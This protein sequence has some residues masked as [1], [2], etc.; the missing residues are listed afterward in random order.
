M[1]RLTGVVVMVAV[2]VMASPAVAA[3]PVSFGVE[4]G[5]VSRDIQEESVVLGTV[6]GVADS[7]RLAARVTLGLAPGLAIFG[8]AGGADLSVDEFNGYRSDLGPLYGGGIQFS[9]PEW[10]SPYRGAAVFFSDL[11]VLRLATSDR[12]VTSVCVSGCQTA[13]P[14]L[15]DDV[16][17]EHLDWTEYALRLGIK[18]RYQT[19]RPFGGIRV[20]KLDGTDAVR[21]VS[22]GLLDE[23]ADVREQDSVGFFLGT[24]VVLDHEE[25][26]AISIQLSGGDENALRVAYNVQ[27]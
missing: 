7:T 10:G 3:P 9:T 1:N 25:R 2:M 13:A 11:A 8:E 15:V 23:R 17:D 26:T 18:G 21:S 22:S 5:S 20:S 12:V 19:F 6:S 16:V 14:T 4:I 24:D 27:F